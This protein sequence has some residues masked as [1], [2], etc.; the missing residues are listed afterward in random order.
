MLVLR[1]TDLLSV[2]GVVTLEPISYLKWLARNICCLTKRMVSSLKPRLK[3]LL[4]VMDYLLF[5]QANQFWCT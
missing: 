5:H 3:R 1:H 2:Q 4:V